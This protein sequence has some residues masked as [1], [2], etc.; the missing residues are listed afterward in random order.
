VVT[1]PNVCSLLGGLYLSF[2]WT[3]FAR[4]IAV[5]GGTSNLVLA[6]LVL[7]SFLILLGNQLR[8]TGDWDIILG[9]PEWARAKTGGA[10]QWVLK[11]RELPGFSIVNEK[12]RPHP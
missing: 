5:A 7:V 8:E 1:V 9:P 11:Q 12:K 6:G 10:D 3:T 2:K 4:A